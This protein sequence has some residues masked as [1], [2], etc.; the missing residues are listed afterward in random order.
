MTASTSRKPVK[1]WGRIIRIFLLGLL[2]MAVGIG[3][4]K[5]RAYQQEQE[6]A[7]FTRTTT[8]DNNP[9]GITQGMAFPSIEEKMPANSY[10]HLLL[11]DSNASDSYQIERNGL[12]YMVIFS[13]S[14]HWQNEPDLNEP[15]MNK[16]RASCSASGLYIN[17]QK[18]PDPA[19]LKWLKD[20]LPFF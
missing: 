14:Y 7:E 6:I 9:W 17:S 4:I 5:W 16:V 8:L 13:A 20:H 10:Q 12:K 18:S 2:V 19:W 1:I 3:W 11:I 15:D